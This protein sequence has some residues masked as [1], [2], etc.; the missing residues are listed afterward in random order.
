MRLHRRYT[1]YPPI[2]AKFV[3]RLQQAADWLT[4]RKVLPEQITVADY[5]AST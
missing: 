5:L 2:D 4:Q 1:F 3:Q